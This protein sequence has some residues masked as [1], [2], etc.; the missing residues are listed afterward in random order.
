MIE[1]KIICDYNKIEEKRK[2]ERTIRQ[3]KKKPSKERSKKTI[4]GIFSFLI[5]LKSP[6]GIR[7]NLII[8]Y[9]L[10][11]KLFFFCCYKSI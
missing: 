2:K 11:Y 8:A 3:R 10:R 5:I 9:I 4:I 6:K 1:K 7:L